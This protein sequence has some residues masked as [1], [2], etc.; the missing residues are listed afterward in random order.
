MYEKIREYLKSAFA[1]APKQTDP[2]Y[3][4]LADTYPARHSALAADKYPTICAY[5]RAYDFM[6]N[7][8]VVYVH[9]GHN[10]A[11]CVLDVRTHLL[12]RSCGVH[13]GMYL[14]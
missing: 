3:A 1:V 7:P 13:H 10:A 2:I 14:C 5:L 6:K 11:V 4:L 12:T 9:K 8:R